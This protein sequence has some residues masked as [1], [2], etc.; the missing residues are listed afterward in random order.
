MWTG[1][2]FDPPFPGPAPLMR[3]RYDVVI[4]GGAV[5]GAA[6]AHFLTGDPGFGGSVLVVER[7]PSFARAAT[8]LSCAS[9]RTQFS[10][11]VNVRMSRF[12][13]EFLRA[14]PDIAETEGQRP[15]LAFHEGG[16]LLL[17]GTEGGAA[18]LRES[19]RVQA[20]SGADVALLSP[21]ELGRAFPHLRT[22][23]LVLGSYGRSGEGWFDGT[24]LMQ[25]LR[26]S[27]RA[28]GADLVRGEVVAIGRA[29]GRAVSVTL[30]SGETVSAGTVVNAAGPNAAA[31]ARMAGLAL[32]VE[33]RKRTVFVFACARSPEGSAA[34]NG[35]RLPLMVDPSGVYCRPEGRLFLAGCVPEPDGAAD[36]DDFEPVHQEF[37]EVIW[38]ALAARS[39]AFEAI[40]EVRRW[41]GHYDYNAFDQNAVIGFDPGL[42]GYVHANGF[43]GHG[44][45]HAPAAG[46]AVAELIVHGGFRT[47]DLSELRPERLRAGRP[48]RENAVI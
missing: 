20:A 7:D 22:E 16:Y 42:E 39:E 1:T 37:E 2:R 46:R 9:I 23:D 15:D 41:A 48:F 17:A 38:P 13:V 18:V 6:A 31:V 43:S 36:P 35:G 47:L 34:V 40:R 28:R 3:A 29:G 11:A 21:D 14:F 8:A 10:N 5:I 25:G 26:R 30:A 24:G 33:P 27:A 19:H 44:L 45:Q 12:G 4:V 32:P